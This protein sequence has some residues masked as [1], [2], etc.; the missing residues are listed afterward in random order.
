MAYIHGQGVAAAAAAAAAAALGRAYR[1]RYSLSDQ[2]VSLPPSIRPS[3][4]RLGQFYGAPHED[5][6]QMSLRPV[7]ITG[8][9]STDYIVI[10][11]YPHHTGSGSVTQRISAISKITR[12]LNDTGLL[13]VMGCDVM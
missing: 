3:P 4:R 5:E 12:D 9:E 11:D 10:V 1:H 8:N 7:T 13:K 2:R 6:R